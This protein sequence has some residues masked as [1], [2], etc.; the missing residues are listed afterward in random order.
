MNFD[1]FHA[2]ERKTL[3]NHWFLLGFEEVQEPTSH[4][5]PGVQPS[6]TS[7]WH[8]HAWEPKT[9]KNYRF[10]LGFEEVRRCPIDS[11]PGSSH[12]SE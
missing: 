1:E 12:R 9:L 2:C 7:Q 10:L 5:D 11:G 3:K 6:E 4:F 8:L